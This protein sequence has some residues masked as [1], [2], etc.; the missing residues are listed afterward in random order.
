MNVRSVGVQRAD[1]YA[2]SSWTSSRNRS[3]AR[4]AT[5]IRSR[6]SGTSGDRPCSVIANVAANAS[7]D[8]AARWMSITTAA[9]AIGR[10]LGRCH[11]PPTTTL[12]ATSPGERGRDHAA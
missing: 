4:N 6:R 11:G 1:G 5:S 2:V 8:G 3:G 9:A 10:V 7:S 12:P